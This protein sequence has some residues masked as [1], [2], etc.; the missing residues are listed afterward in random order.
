MI[1]RWPAENGCKGTHMSKHLTA[2]EV[3]ALLDSLRKP[4][5]QYAELVVKKGINVQPGQEVV[6]TAPIERADFV[7]QLVAKA[8]EA[9]AG[10][11][12]TLWTDDALARLEYQ[13]VSLSYF[14]HTP[15]W[16][17]EQLDSL[18]ESGAAFLMVV[19]TDPHALDGIDPAKPMTAIR[20]RNEQCAVYRNGLDFGKNAWSIVGAPIEKWATTVFPHYAPQEAVYRL[21]RAILLAARADGADPQAEWE[22]HDATFQKNKR[23]LNGYAFDALRYTSSNGTNLEVGLNEGHIWGGGGACTVGGTAFFPNMPTEEVFTSPD[24]TRTS[25]VVHAVMPLV[26]AGR[27]VRDFW[28]RFDEGRVVDFGAVEGCDVLKGIVEADEHSC[29]LGECALISKDTPI[30]QSGLLFYHTLYDENASCHLALGTGFPECLEGGVAMSQEE[31]LAHGVNQSHTH[32]DFMIGAD[33]LE[34][35]GITKSG[36]EVPV[37]VDGRWAW[38][39]S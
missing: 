22:R 26:H 29:Y 39:V 27:I 16:K 8:Y 36:D 18:A 3:A 6:V 5:E 24:R 15:A 10:H 11:V 35:T 30:R 25:G 32:V 37:F 1:G 23:I 31:L 7:R 4:I 21:W 13:N 38:S 33:D 28:L 14:E 12:T 19:G 34:V 20:A 9:G 17:R 2:A